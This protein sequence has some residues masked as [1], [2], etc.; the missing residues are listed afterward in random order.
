M[1]LLELP[2]Y[3]ELSTAELVRQ[4]LKWQCV[5][6][7]MLVGHVIMSKLSAVPFFPI[8]LL[9]LGWL[10]YKAPLAG[11]LVFFQ[12]LIYQNWVLSILSVG[13]DYSTFTMLQGSS[14]AALVLMAGISFTRLV[15]SKR[16]RHLD[17]RLL[18]AVKLALLMSCIY[19][20]YGMTKAGITPT[21]VYFREATSLVLAVPI[22]L[23]VGRVWGYRTV[24]TGFLV[25]AALSI[26]I[27]LVEISAPAPYYDLIN[28]PNYTNLKYSKVGSSVKDPASIN[29]VRT[30]KELA[31]ANSAVFFN[32]TGSETT[33]RSFR[34]IGTVIHPISYAYILAGCAVIALSIGAGQWLWLL[35]PLL[36][37]IGV[38]GANLQ[39]ACSLL[40]W[41][42]WSLT[43]NRNFLLTS[44]FIMMVGYV[45]FGLYFGMDRGDFHVIGFM[46][47]VHGLLAN[48]IGHGLGMG[49]NFSPQAMMHIKWDSLQHFG[50]DFAVE[51]AVG[52][53][54]YQM[55][56]ASITVFAVIALL[57]KDAPCGVKGPQRRDICL[58][59]LATVTVNGIFQEEAYTSYACG[60][61]TLLCAVIVA[62][63]YRTASTYVP[64]CQNPALYL[65]H[66]IAA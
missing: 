32:I 21:A 49:G 56:I 62:N 36:V 23:D 3:A 33:S 46:G 1:K 17:G 53:L 58:I 28:A 7:A 39:F 14:F 12:W 37:T 55:G 57:L 8:A 38:K 47:G 18:G 19:A 2:P 40:L 63:G 24:G 16:W 51:S 45:A 35:L 61:F 65:P 29:S 60:L 59:G 20:V 52:V 42:V 34:F 26:V 4:T 54:I 15:S 22:G 50:A 64:T 9:V 44:G 31:E 30:G 48:P 6:L 10:Y 5:G 66:Q 27:S 11:L 41:M 43:R 13:M 25:S